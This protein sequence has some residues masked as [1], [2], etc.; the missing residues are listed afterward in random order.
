MT[1]HPNTVITVPEFALAGTPATLLGPSTRR[2]HML[3][4]S[5]LVM[6]LLAAGT[7]ALHNIHRSGDFSMH[8]EGTHVMTSIYFA[9]LLTD[10]PLSHPVQYT[11]EFYAR[12][13]TLGLIHWPPFFPFMEGLVFRFFGP[14]ILAARFTVLLFFLVGLTF[15]FLLI[16]ELLNPWAAAFAALAMAL[17][18][19]VVLYEQ[20]VMLEIPSLALCIVGTY[21]WLGFLR[22]QRTRT[23]AWFVIT[24]SLAVLT[25]QHSIY[26][27]PFCLFS[28][29]AA[30]KWRSLVSRRGLII[31]GASA[32]L[33]V[34][35]YVLAVKVHLSSI[36]DHVVPK[37][38][39]GSSG[40]LFYLRAVPREIGW[41][42]LGLSLS[43]IALSCWWGRR[44]DAAVML[45]WI[46]A[47]LLTF[48]F[49]NAREPRYFMYAL[50]PI[51]Y[52]ACWPFAIDFRAPR[53]RFVLCA[54]S[55][56]LLFV[57]VPADWHT[58]YSSVSGYGDAVHAI[59]SGIPGRE[60]LL[61]DGDDVDSANVGFYLRL[62]DR[63]RRF[64]LF[65]KGLYATRI[66][67]RFG[68]T[69]LVRNQSE[70][71]S[72]LAGYGI[73]HVLVADETEEF[74]PSQQV[75][76]DLLKTPQFKL[77][78]TFPITWD[79]A[80]HHLLLYENQAASKPT[81][82]DLHLPMMTL[83]HDIVVPLR[84]LGIQ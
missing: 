79:G 65:R 81:L 71:Q 38:A 61:F 73:K 75:L 42:V 5:L 47:C 12:Y 23:L 32:L 80:A 76:R 30:G 67:A 2:Q 21:F 53:L 35:F 63:Q 74:H 44:R 54:A 40:L 17:L 50:P 83:D 49:L 68:S 45:S 15:W 22:T 72:M 7:V 9:D 69:E 59:V 13:S 1:E 31:L 60:V 78:A 14:T 41:P 24:A 26:L 39:F 52:F 64:V 77:I 34:P 70:L 62:Q 28:A 18:P 37:H 4:A 56:V 51:V 43:G 6:V 20:A 27:V 36:A 3:S 16:R 58:A 10:L 82:T 33:V 29:I 46:L 11:Y 84:A 8:D 19:T 48:S 55:V 66:M 57:Y 25:K